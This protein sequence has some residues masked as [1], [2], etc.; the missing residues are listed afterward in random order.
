MC[1]CDNI[2]ERDNA[3]TLNFFFDYFTDKLLSQKV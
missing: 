1:L 3:S 2:L